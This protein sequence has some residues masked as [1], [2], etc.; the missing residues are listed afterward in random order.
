MGGEWEG[1]VGSGGREK[2]FVRDVCPQLPLLPPYPPP[3][4]EETDLCGFCQRVLLSS[5]LQLYVWPM[6]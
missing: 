2:P 6:V 4:P 3:A 5:G 1:E